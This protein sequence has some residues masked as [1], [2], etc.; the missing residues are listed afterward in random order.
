MCCS[1]SKKL[2]KSKP[3]YSSIFYWG[4]C[5]EVVTFLLVFRGILRW[6]LNLNILVNKPSAKVEL[7]ALNVCQSDHRNWCPTS[8]LTTVI[9][10]VHPSWTVVYIIAELIG[11]DAHGLHRLTAWAIIP[12]LR[13]SES[14]LILV[15]DSREVGLFLGK[16]IVGRRGM[17]IKDVGTIWTKGN[18][19]I[20]T[21]ML[22]IMCM[23]HSG[24]GISWLINSYKKCPKCLTC[25]SILK[26]LFLSQ[27]NHIFLLSDL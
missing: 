18:H 7:G 25:H 12:A 20:V 14:A 27:L 10:F 3:R 24:S 21:C 8:A 23:A 4:F 26:F 22:W 5:L 6:L 11:M 9:G 16:V 1:F 19:S 13:L 2:Q 15:G 17:E